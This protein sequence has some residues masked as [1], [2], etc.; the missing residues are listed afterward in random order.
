MQYQ[1]KKITHKRWWMIIPGGISLAIGITAGYLYMSSQ[2]QFAAVI[3]VIFLLAGG[4]L[5]Y[6]GMKKPGALT[7][8]QMIKQ[9]G[10]PK[11]VNC[12]SILAT[13]NPESENGHE[14]PLVI[15]FH[16]A[17]RPKGTPRFIVNLK[18]HMFVNINDTLKKKMMPVKLPD[19]RYASP[20]V[21]PV[22][23]NMPR[24][25]EYMEYTPPSMLQKIAP[26]ILLVAIIIIGILMVATG[27]QGGTG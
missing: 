5:L 20:A 2:N 15:K 11:E 18:K 26:G 17:L 8:Y 1:A 6:S 22:H 10:I 24:F 4:I 14:V 13:R 12:I 3:T 27:P 7:G 9:R 25:R 19:K 16:R 21:F 23:S